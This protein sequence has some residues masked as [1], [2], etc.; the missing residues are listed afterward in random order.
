MKIIKPDDKDRIRQWGHST[1]PTRVGLFV[2]FESEDENSN[3][4]SLKSDDSVYVKRTLKTQDL[5]KYPAFALRMIAT[6]NEIDN[7]ELTKQNRRAIIDPE[8]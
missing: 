8:N 7:L 6:K 1:Y 2:E 5:I 3:S 4:F